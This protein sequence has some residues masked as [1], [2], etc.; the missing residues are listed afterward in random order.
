MIKIIY[1]D[2]HLIAVNKTAGILVQGDETGDTPLSELIKNYLKEKYQKQGNVFVGV[3]HRLDRPVSGVVLFAK[4]SKALARMNAAFSERTTQ[5]IYWAL[6]KGVPLQQQGKL[7]HWLLKNPSNNTVKAVPAHTKNAQ[8]AELSYQLLAQKSN[9][10]LLEVYPLTGR[11]H[12]I[13]VQL[14]K[15]NCVIVGDVKYG[16]PVP[17][18]DASICLHAKQLTFEH[19]TKKEIITIQADLPTTTAWKEWKP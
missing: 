16:Y 7:V 5:K 14:A 17:N 11:P 2:N 1:E 15:M 13:R 19:P 4:T 12:Q 10:S 8:Y 9:N 18:D 3:I 6:V